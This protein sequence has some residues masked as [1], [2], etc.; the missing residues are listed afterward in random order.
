MTRLVR[1]LLVLESLALTRVTCFLSSIRTITLGRSIQVE[2]YVLM[3]Q[4]LPMV[5]QQHT[6]PATFTRSRK[7]TK[8]IRRKSHGRGRTVIASSLT[9]TFRSPRNILRLSQLISR[10]TPVRAVASLTFSS[11]HRRPQAT[12]ISWLRVPTVA[13]ATR[14][15]VSASKGTRTTTVMFRARSLFKQEASC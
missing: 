4:I 9:R 7:F 5:H 13:R 11:F 6:S 3:D 15:R 10:R 1:Q 2:H 14:A 8:K 12:T